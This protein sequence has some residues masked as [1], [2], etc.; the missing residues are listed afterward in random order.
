MLGIDGAVDYEAPEYNGEATLVV[1]PLEAMPPFVGPGGKALISVLLWRILSAVR[2]HFA[3]ER[4][5]YVSGALL[6]R[7]QPPPKTQRGFTS[8]GDR[9][10]Y[11]VAHVDRAN[12]ASYD[13]SAVLYLNGKG[14]PA[15]GGFEG[16]DFCF[17]DDES[18]EIV[19]PRAGRCVLFTS[20][21]EQLHRVCRVEGGTRFALATW[22]TL[23]ERASDGPVDPAPYAIVNPVPPPSKEEME[24]EVVDID[25]LRTKV[26]RKME[27]DNV[28]QSLYGVGGQ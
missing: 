1:S 19:E 17:V 5:L 18:D 7:L 2:E 21:F 22:F 10:D 6:T 12:V 26:E 13:Y 3:E 28:V 20:G 27:Q 24:A 15:A 16:G 11:D 23:D 8:G 14:S 25:E 4:P 9:Y